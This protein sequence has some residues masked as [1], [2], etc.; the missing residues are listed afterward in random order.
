MRKDSI[1]ASMCLTKAEISDESC[2]VLNTK[3]KLDEK[4][5]FGNFQ[6]TIIKGTFDELQSLLRLWKVSPYTIITESDYEDLSLNDDYPLWKDFRSCEKLDL[7]MCYI[8]RKN[9]PL[10]VICGNDLS[11]YVIAVKNKDLNQTQTFK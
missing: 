7:P 2:F 3:I 6:H 11:S 4:T 8:Y 1:L 10:F 5:Y 9:Y